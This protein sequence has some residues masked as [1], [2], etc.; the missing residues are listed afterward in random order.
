MG[1]LQKIPATLR[2]T[3]VHLHSCRLRTD[4]MD[5]AHAA[6]V[7]VTTTA[8]LATHHKRQQVRLAS[9]FKKGV[10]T[11]GYEEPVVR[12]CIKSLYRCLPGYPPQR[13]QQVGSAAF[14]LSAIFATL[15]D[16]ISRLNEMA[17]LAVVKIKAGKQL[18]S[19]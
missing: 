15:T 10:W 1:T 4:L 12:M 14:Q 11:E 8:C 19:P 3:L 16:R 7:L 18:Q 9:I 5:G 13:Q 17:K 6:D 2:H